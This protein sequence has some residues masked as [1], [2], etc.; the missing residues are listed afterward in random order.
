MTGNT[1]ASHAVHLYVLKLHAASLLITTFLCSE[2]GR[3]SLGGKHGYMHVHKAAAT[4]IKLYKTAPTTH[5]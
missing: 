2:Q 5:Q 3:L 1:Q 4:K